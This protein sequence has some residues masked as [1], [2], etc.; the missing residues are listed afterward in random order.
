MISVS[1]A[2]QNSPAL[3]L[4]TVSWALVEVPR[5]SYYLVKQFGEPV[6]FHTW[7][8]YSLF[9]VLY[10]M[11]IAGEIGNLLYSFPEAAEITWAQGPGNY[12]NIVY[13]HQVV[14]AFL[15]I[16]YIPGSY[17]M[18]SHMWRE[19]GKQL[20]QEKTKQG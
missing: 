10:P 5:Y 20:S 13:S 8:R 11:G 15:L 7:I 12:L 6:Y 19:R 1:K 3:L 18:I 14:L 2:A 16:L 4:C 9:I 17:L